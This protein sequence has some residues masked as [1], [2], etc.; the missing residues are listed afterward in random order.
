MRKINNKGFAITGILYALLV[1][2]LSVLVF[3]L[4]NLKSNRAMLERSIVT[5]EGTYQGTEKDI[6]L[7]QQAEKTKIAPVTGKYIFN[8]K[9]TDKEVT[10]VSYLKKYSRIDHSI[11]FIPNDCNIYNYSFSYENSQSESI[12]TLT[13]IYSFEGW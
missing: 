1:M 2:F 6:S 9:S 3:V 8:L 4:S 7:V 10:C 13:K 11:T 5:L 12:I